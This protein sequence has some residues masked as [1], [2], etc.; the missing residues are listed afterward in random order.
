MVRSGKGLTTSLTLRTK[1]PN[2]KQKSRISI[3]GITNQYFRK[4]LRK[5]NNSPYLGYKKKQVHNEPT[6]AYFL[7]INHIYRQIKSKKHVRL[8]NKGVRSDVNRKKRI[9]KTIGHV[10]KTIQSGITSLNV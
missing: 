7:L 10:S 8:H 4:F 5:F 1:K 9:N 2:K 6:E 3:T